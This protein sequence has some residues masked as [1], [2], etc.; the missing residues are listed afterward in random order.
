MFVLL[1]SL[2]QKLKQFM[3]RDA[4]G[5]RDWLEPGGTEDL[6]TLWGASAYEKNMEKFRQAVK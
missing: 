3:E 2:G 4:Q 1:S 6:M 5:K